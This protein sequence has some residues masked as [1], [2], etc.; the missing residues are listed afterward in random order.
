MW[1]WVTKSTAG[2]GSASPSLLD[3]ELEK[4]TSEDSDN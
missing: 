2:E 1:K 4:N 3:T